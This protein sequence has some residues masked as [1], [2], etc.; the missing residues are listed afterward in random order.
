ME[1][2]VHQQEFL[3][4]FISSNEKGKRETTE[5]FF[6]KS[7]MIIADFRTDVKQILSRQHR[8]TFAGQAS[9]ISYFYSQDSNLLEMPQTFRSNNCPPR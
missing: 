9:G 5:Y 4:T 3:D 8:A 6:N 7:R 2:E 1:V